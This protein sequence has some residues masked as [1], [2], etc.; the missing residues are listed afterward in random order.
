MSGGHKTL[1]I[2]EILFPK[3]Q[4]NKFHIL[5]MSKGAMCLSEALGWK[6]SCKMQILIHVQGKTQFWESGM[7]IITGKWLL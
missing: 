2:A 1:Q 4:Q 7:E 3:N 5:A 6:F